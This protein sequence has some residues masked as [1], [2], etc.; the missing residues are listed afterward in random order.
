MNEIE[1]EAFAEKRLAQLAA[2]GHSWARPVPVSIDVRGRR[3]D[4]WIKPMTEKPLADQ[5]LVFVP[6][7]KID[8]RR[9]D[10]ALASGLH[11]VPGELDRSQK[12]QLI[13]KI[14]VVAQ[15]NS[16]P[17]TNDAG[18]QPPSNS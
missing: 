1:F 13:N 18:K 7:L 14:A 3:P 5:Q 8:R 17:K 9:M 6:G 11:E 4:E 12:R 15:A 10:A 16:A 2:E